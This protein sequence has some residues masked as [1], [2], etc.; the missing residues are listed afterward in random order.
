MI[1]A[2]QQGLKDDD[3]EVSL[4]KLCRWFDV[5]RRSTYYRPGKSAPK[6]QECFVALIEEHL[7]FGYRHLLRMNKNTVQRVFQFKGWLVRKRPVGFQ[8]RIQALPPVAKAP[9]ERW[10]TDLCQVWKVRDGCCGSAWRW[11]STVTH[12]NCWAGT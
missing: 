5:H 7:S 10:A 4:L 11:S 1:L 12:A 6:L 8:P 9:N 3:T 2:L